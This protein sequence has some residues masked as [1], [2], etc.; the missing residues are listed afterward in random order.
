MLPTK[1]LCYISLLTSFSFL[2]AASAQ[3]EPAQENAPA[4]AAGMPSRQEEQ[5]QLGQ[6]AEFVKECRAR[7][8]T[9]VCRL[10]LEGLAAEKEILIRSQRFEQT[11]YGCVFTMPALS[12]MVHQNILP[13]EV[14]YILKHGERAQAHNPNHLIFYISL[15]GA[16]PAVVVDVE[17]GKI[18]KVGRCAHMGYLNPPYDPAG[19]DEEAPR[20]IYADQDQDR[21]WFEGFNI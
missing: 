4:P 8:A 1:S 16:S 21:D 7:L 3:Q 10:N 17:T 5:K 14:I 6:I 9:E 15:T 11:I 2:N 20:Q 13:S 18:I 12:G 19:E